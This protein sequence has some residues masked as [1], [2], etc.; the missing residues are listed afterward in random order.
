[1]D[2]IAALDRA[3]TR[4]VPPFIAG[5]LA[6]GMVVLALLPDAETKC[7][8]TL[9]EQGGRVISIIEGKEK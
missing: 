5:I 7:H 3:I 6:A 4:A 1:M 9:K 2:K 8:C